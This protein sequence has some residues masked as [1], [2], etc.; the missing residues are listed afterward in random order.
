MAL[1]EDI[2]RAITIRDTHPIREKFDSETLDFLY[3]LF[4][5]RRPDKFFNEVNEAKIISGSVGYC[6]GHRCFR[7]I[8]DNGYVWWASTMK[9]TSKE[10]YGRCRD[11]LYGRSE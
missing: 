1:K 8:F 3:R 10:F 11:A 6:N 2:I 5:W 7:F 4:L 9:L